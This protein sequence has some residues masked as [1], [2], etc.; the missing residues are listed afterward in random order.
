MTLGPL[1][2]TCLF[3]DHFV[4]ALEL[5]LFFGIKAAWEK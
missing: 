2:M 4:Y 1:F 3:L 5:T